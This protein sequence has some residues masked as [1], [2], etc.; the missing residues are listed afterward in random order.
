[1]SMSL[2]DQEVPRLEE[3]SSVSVAEHVP[4]ANEA[5]SSVEN[6]EN[7]GIETINRDEQSSSGSMSVH[8]DSIVSDYEDEQM[9]D[10]DEDLRNQL[11]GLGESVKES[12]PSAD[13]PDTTL[14][15]AG[16]VYPM[17]SKDNDNGTD[18]NEQQ[19]VVIEDRSLIHMEL[20][21]LI[22]AIRLFL[23][24]K[25]GALSLASKEILLHFPSLDLLCNEDN[26]Y[27]KKMTMDD[28]ISIFKV[29]RT[30]SLRNGEENVPSTL[31]IV[32][33]LQPRFVSRYNDLVEV[34]DNNGSFAVV[35]GFSNDESHPV[36][37]DEGNQDGSNFTG[38]RS[39]EVIVMDS[40]EASLKDSDSDIEIIN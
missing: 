37:V 24:N 16:E 28:I 27:I 11:K 2:E 22:A 38:G 3:L 5:G 14:E 1:M 17:F 21:Y 9:I 39:S 30:N 29:L 4:E 33:S 6:D 34:M 10:S 19:S 23:Q 15:Y 26:L 32:V 13:I 25:H 31:R 20:N 7:D 40:D 8:S 35:H 18:N 36:F 12:L